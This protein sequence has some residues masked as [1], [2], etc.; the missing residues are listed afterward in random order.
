M[1]KQDMTD[2][3]K[4]HSLSFINSFRFRNSVTGKPG[5]S[6]LDE[7]LQPAKAAAHYA[8]H[9]Q[10]VTSIAGLQG[11]RITT[12]IKSK[13]CSTH[14]MGLPADGFHRL[15]YRS[16]KLQYLETMWREHITRTHTIHTSNTCS[17]YTNK[18]ATIKDNQEN[19]TLCCLPGHFP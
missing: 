14:L 18:S 15:L 3:R 13:R 16:L 4:M 17:L 7:P 2:F 9:V 8:E 6:P 19:L 12:D 5:N 10:H 1:S 11:E